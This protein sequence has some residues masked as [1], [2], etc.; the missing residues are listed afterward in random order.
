MIETERLLLRRNAV[1]DFQAIS[2]IYTDPEVIKHIG[3]GQPASAQDSWFR[4]L[5]HVGHWTLFGYGFFTVVEK[6]SG[7]FAGLV[8]FADFHRELGVDFDPFPE[9]GWTLAT[10]AHGKGYATEA[11][12]AAH[13][14]F[15][16][17][18]GPRR[19]VCIIDHDNE[20]SIKVA[21]KLGYSL[22]GPR[23]YRDESILVFERLP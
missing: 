15:E 23:A 13:S 4:L 5:R 10:W 1:E 9:G 19:T 11:A 20:P 12:I 18:H 3:V 2:E 14:W 6:A 21:K 8:G 22:V 7:R 16:E 17:T